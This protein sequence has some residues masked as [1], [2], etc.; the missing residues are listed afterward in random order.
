M[1]HDKRSRERCRSWTVLH[2]QCTGALSSEFPIPQG[3]KT[4]HRLICCFFSNICAKNY[5]NRFVCVKITA[6]QRWNVVLRHSVFLDLVTCSKNHVA[7]NK[8]D[9]QPHS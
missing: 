1:V 9:H 8:I 4:K 5:R 6:S 7:D 3:W 2:A